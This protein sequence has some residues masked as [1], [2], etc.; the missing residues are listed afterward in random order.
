MTAL[1]ASRNRGAPSPRRRALPLGLAPWLRFLADGLGVRLGYSA[2]KTRRRILSAARQ[3]AGRLSMSAFRP[4]TKLTKGHMHMLSNGH[5]HMYKDICLLLWPHVAD[6]TYPPDTKPSGEPRRG[7]AVVRH[8]T[9]TRPC[10]RG[11]AA[12]CGARKA[13]TCAHAWGKARDADRRRTKG[14]RAERDT[15]HG[16]WRG[17]WAGS[18]W[19]EKRCA[20]RGSRHPGRA[21]GTEMPAMRKTRQSGT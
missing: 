20:S 12:P 5:M 14:R 6:T 7:D 21:E 10:G 3:R 16:R 19:S 18:A 15:G 4:E 11:V 8:F 9:D 17:G 1:A 2:T 13:V